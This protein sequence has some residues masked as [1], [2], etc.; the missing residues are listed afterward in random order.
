[1]KKI[2]LLFTYF[3]LGSFFYQCETE[4][5]E[6]VASEGIQPVLL[7]AEIP[8]VLVLDPA[9]SGDN[10]INFSWQEADYNV[11]TQVDYWL[12]ID[13]NQDFTE[14]IIVASTTQRSI[15]LLVTQLNTA[16]SN[17]GL[18]PFQNGTAFVRIRSSIG[19]NSVLPQ[20]SNV[21]SFT[22]F[23]Y[24][25]EL[26][27]LYLVG[28][29]QSDSGYGIVNADGPTLASSEF[30]NETNYEGFVYFG[31]SDLSFQLHRAGFVGEY[32]DGNPVYGNDGD[33][34]VE[35]AAGTFTAP[36]EGYY[37]VEVNL[38]AGTINFTETN[39]GLIGPG[40]PSGNWDADENMTYNIEAQV[41]EFNDASTSNGEFK[42]RANDAWD[43]NFGGD[44]NGDGSLDYGG[45]NFE[46]STNASRFI[47][48]LSNPRAYTFSISND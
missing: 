6:F 40:S 30:G 19:S 46:N 27:R 21:I 28:G 33:S 44:D 5:I 24:T 43:I 45:S 41:W 20:Y 2:F 22:V 13:D 37:R 39:W 14:P 10:I 1:M 9:L 16:V 12:E 31:G 23:P 25:T 42:F 3:I 34:V 4:N 7:E 11:P 8:D 29:F 36:A 35:G 26:P 18:A 47:L 17:A 48:D 32:V 38:D 15:S